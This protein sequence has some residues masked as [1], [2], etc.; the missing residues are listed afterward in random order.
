MDSG[1]F[2]SCRG[3]KVRSQSPDATRALGRQ[4]GAGL[5]AGDCL[6]LSGELGAGKTVIAQG[7]VAGAGGGEDVRSPTFLLA[8]IYQ[9]RIPLHH[10]DLYRLEGGCDLRSLGIDEALVDGAVIVEWP[11]RATPDWFTGRIALEIASATERV[12]QLE[13]R[14]GLR[15]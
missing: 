15:E 9:G 3:V 7:I 10:L 4:I 8:V 5:Q 6:A 11:E 2:E 12:I 14:D 13:L 1:T